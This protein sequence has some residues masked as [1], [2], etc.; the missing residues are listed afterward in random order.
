MVGNRNIGQD[1][2]FAQIPSTIVESDILS[3]TK[4]WVKYTNNNENRRRGK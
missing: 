4:T 3:F 2:I 1:K